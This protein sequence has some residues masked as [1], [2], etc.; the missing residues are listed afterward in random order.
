[1]TSLLCKYQFFS[2]TCSITAR[3]SNCFIICFVRCFFVSVPNTFVLQRLKSMLFELLDIY[4]HEALLKAVETKSCSLCHFIRICLHHYFKS[5]LCWHTYGCIAGS[6][7]FTLDLSTTPELSNTV[8]ACLV[9]F[10]MTTFCF[11][12]ILSKVFLEVEIRRLRICMH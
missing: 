2:S 8:L 5:Q 3:L 6:F 10:Y 12:L 9:T 4:M 11:S 7:S 1:M